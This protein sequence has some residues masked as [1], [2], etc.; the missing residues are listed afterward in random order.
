MKNQ[1]MAFARGMV[2]V[3]LTGK[4]MERFINSLNRAHLSIWHVRRVGTDAIVF[5]IRLQDLSQL[6]KLARKSECSIKLMYG[7]GLPFLW[8]RIWKN[9]GFLFGFT[10]FIAL[11]FFLSNIIWNIQ[12]KGASPEIEH[13]IQNEL[14]DLGVYRGK[15]LFFVQNVEKIQ[16]EL[17]NRIPD[18]TWVGVQIKGTTFDFQVV[19]KNTP[20]PRESQPAQH[21]I[22]NKKAVIVDMFVE[23]GKPVVQV[24]DYVKKG[25]LLVSGFIGLEDKPKIVSSRGKVWGQTWY[26][27]TTEVALQTDFEVLSGSEKE[28]R[29]LRI[30][31]LNLL[32]WGFGKHSFREYHQEDDEKSFQ[33]LGFTLPVKYVKRTIR[34]KET[35]TREWTEKEGVK[36]A[37]EL[38]LKDLRAFLPKDAKVIKEN[39]LHEQVKNGKVKLTIYFQVIENIAVEQPIIKETEE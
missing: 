36:R 26:K 13:K 7:K 10:L 34:E 5:F 24:H 2:L 14:K 35:V 3:K 16:H 20:K 28:R 17:T 1:W 23:E 29:Y 37:Q 21:L 12:I 27:T 31:N 30:G 8:K 32:F 22:A 9:N 38:A 18:L 11:L 4:G 19:E 6:R 33:F 15:L 39:I 25:Q